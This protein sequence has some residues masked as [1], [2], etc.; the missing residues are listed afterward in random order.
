[1]S[2]VF[3]TQTDSNKVTPTKGQKLI[4]VIRG[5][6]LADVGVREHYWLGHPYGG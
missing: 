6:S 2:P 1:M 3:A 4:D 5:A